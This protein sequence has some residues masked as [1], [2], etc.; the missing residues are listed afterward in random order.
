M[1]NTWKLQEAKNRFNQL[2]DNALEQGPQV[3]TCRG[4]DTL[5][6]LSIEEYKKSKKD[7]GSMAEFL[8]S[9]PLKGSGLFI[10]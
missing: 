7:E 4:K 3:I 10:K 6:L 1:T 8:L 9:S 5:V 2:V